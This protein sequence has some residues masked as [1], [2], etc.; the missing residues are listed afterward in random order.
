MNLSELTAL[1]PLDGRYAANAAALRSIFSE[2]GLFKYR[3]QVEIQWIIA[4]SN[5]P[6]IVEVP[7]LSA[8]ALITLKAI[9]HDF[10][11]ED[12]IE[13][14]R[15][16]TTT[17]H[18]V[19]AVEYF[20]K[21]KMAA[22]PELNQIIEYVHFACTSE[23]INN[24]SYGLMLKEGRTVLIQEATKIHATIDLR[25][26]DWANA[27]MISR[28]HGQ[29]ASPTT[30]GKE[31]ANVAARLDRA[32][33]RIHRVNILGKMNGAVGNFNAHAL[34]YPEVDWPAASKS[35]VESL[36]LHY[37]PLTTQI[38]PHDWTAEL[39]DAIFGLNTILID[40]S[41]D[42]WSYISMNY[43]SQHLVEGEVGSSTMP[44][45]INPID[46]ENAEG[47]LGLSNAIAHHMSAKLP[48]SRLQRDLSDSTVQR[49]FGLVFGYTLVACKSLERGLG[50]LT[51]NADNLKR[52]LDTHWELLGEG[53]QTVM[54]RYGIEAPYEKLKDLTRGKTLTAEIYAN[55]VK[56]QNLPEEVKSR[57]LNLTPSQYLGFA[58]KLV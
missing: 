54:R 24:L 17:R 58:N 45:K 11:L 52:E 28:T 40:F 35:F 27:S 46:F 55:F 53:L 8:D 29:A 20:I 25:S 21:N 30:M 57:L 15:I 49:N 33:D 7:K 39:M 38:E 4:L 47:N 1:S 36:G 16:E 5:I 6:E 19:K 10:S 42:V 9:A 37:N 50:K 14:K 3:V 48:I 12:A 51:L 41:R 43:F 18:D 44:H 13:I 31:W 34:A 26:K 2:F 56:D 22:N 32:L 23:D